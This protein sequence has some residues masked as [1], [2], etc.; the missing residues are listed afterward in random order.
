MTA[1]MTGGTETGME[2]MSEQKTGMGLGAV[3]QNKSGRMKIGDISPT[4]PSYVS[5]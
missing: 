5:P 2:L 1:M 4:A 3:C